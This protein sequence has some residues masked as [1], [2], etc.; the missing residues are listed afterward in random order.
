MLW[1]HHHAHSQAPDKS[2][3]R[4]Q[5]VR[6]RGGVKPE[7]HPEGCKSDVFEWQDVEA[8][9]VPEGQGWQPHRP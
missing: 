7:A 5:P 2:T 9:Q 1:L 8:C 3:A 4:E 6:L